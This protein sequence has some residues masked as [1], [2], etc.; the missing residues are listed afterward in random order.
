MT[1]KSLLDSASEEEMA[2]ALT[3]L[4]N[5]KKPGNGLDSASE[6]VRAHACNENCD[7][8]IELEV[9]QAAG[10]GGYRYGS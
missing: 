7:C 6:T 1:Q 5:F 10:I 3:F 8:Y 4:R 2:E 9:L